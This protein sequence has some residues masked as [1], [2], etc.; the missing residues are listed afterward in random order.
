MS[1]LNTSLPAVEIPVVPL[2]SDGVP[3]CATGE[4]QVCPFLCVE[5]LSENL[6]CSAHAGDDG[7]YAPISREPGRKLKPHSSCP[8]HYE[9]ERDALRSKLAGEDSK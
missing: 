5:P 8:V 9:S 1:D 7:S 6:H 4:L 2:L 3:Q